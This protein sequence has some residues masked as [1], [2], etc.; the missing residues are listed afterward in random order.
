MVEVGR[1]WEGVRALSIGICEGEGGRLRDSGGR[2]EEIRGKIIIEDVKEE[3]E[4][5]TG[6]DT[7]HCPLARDN[8]IWLPGKQISIQTCPTDNQ[9][10]CF[11]VDV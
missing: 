11:F 1:E 6:L 8:Q 10:F 5:M 7:K 3:Q 4:E 2:P 9:G